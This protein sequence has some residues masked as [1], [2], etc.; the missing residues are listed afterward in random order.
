MKK[1]RIVEVSPKDVVEQATKVLALL[2]LHTPPD[3]LAAALQGSPL[4]ASRQAL[5]EECQDLA[6][7]C[8]NWIPT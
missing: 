6:K 3:V 8:L 7:K 1:L 5:A 4:Y 2:Q